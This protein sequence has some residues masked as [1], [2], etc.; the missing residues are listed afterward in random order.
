MVVYL[1]GWAAALQDAPRA[2]RYTGNPTHKMHRPRKRGGHSRNPV[3]LCAHHL[4]KFRSSTSRGPGS[5]RQRK[6]PLWASGFLEFPSGQ[7]VKGRAA[8]AGGAGRSLP[9]NQGAAGGPSRQPR[10]S[11]DC[12]WTNTAARTTQ[13]MAS[14]AWAAKQEG[15]DPSRPV[16]RAADPRG[17]EGED[18]AGTDT[19]ADDPPVLP[20]SP[21]RDS[22]QRHLKTGPETPR[23]GGTELRGARPAHRRPLCGCAAPQP[24]QLRL[25]EPLHLT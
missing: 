8:T 24:H 11:L 14:R 25:P 17:A 23:E 9:G 3:G 6:L 22:A 19:V 12:N 13:G 10:T 18:D 4:H 15:L 7:G 1:T 21:L 5:R 16:A 2:K 20:P